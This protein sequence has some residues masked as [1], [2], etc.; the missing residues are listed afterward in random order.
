MRYTSLL[1]VLFVMAAP[2]ATF[3][4]SD[5]APTENKQPTS[6]EPESLKS[7]LEITKSQS[8]HQEQTLPSDEPPL[9][10]PTNP[11]SSNPENGICRNLTPDEKKRNPL[12]AR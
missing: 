9:P 7:R 8:K 5:Q 2:S 1:V 3:A 11:G 10:P 6:A 4:Q 12:C